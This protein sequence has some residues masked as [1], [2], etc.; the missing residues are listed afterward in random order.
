[1]MYFNL[2]LILTVSIYSQQINAQASCNNYATLVYKWDTE[3]YFTDQLRHVAPCTCDSN[4]EYISDT[5]DCTA[6]FNTSDRQVSASNVC[7]IRKLPSFSLSLNDL[8]VIE[9]S[10]GNFFLDNIAAAQPYCKQVDPSSSKHYLVF[11][12]KWYG[13]SSSSNSMYGSMNSMSSMSTWTPSCDWFYSLSYQ[14]DFTTDF[15]THYSKCSC[16]GNDQYAVDNYDCT[17]YDDSNKSQISVWKTCDVRNSTI[18]VPHQKDIIVNDKQTGKYYVD[19]LSGVA[20]SCK[21]TTQ[22]SNARYRIVFNG[23]YPSS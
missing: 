16:D 14:W 9:K 21:K 12:R 18:F 1:M 13:S 2:C 4:E 10:T 23:K 22:P 20:S 19:S 17:G 11:N 5:Y 3:A 7:D 15:P 8:I 6:R